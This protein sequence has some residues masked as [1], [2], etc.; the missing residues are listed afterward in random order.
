[1]NRAALAFYAVC[2]TGLGYYVGWALP[3]VT[4]QEGFR[5]AGLLVCGWSCLLAWRSE[6][7]RDA[8]VPLSVVLPLIGYEWG[9][10]KLIGVVW[11]FT[12]TLYMV[13]VRVR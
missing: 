4:A 11:A 13:P 6:D 2:W 12:L 5:A 3:L 1:M 8:L 9:I 10:W 7:L